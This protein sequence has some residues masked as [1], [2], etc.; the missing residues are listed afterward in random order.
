MGFRSLTDV[1]V[2]SFDKG[3]KIMGEHSFCN[4]FFF[5]Q[6][7]MTGFINTW[8]CSAVQE[9]CSVQVEALFHGGSKEAL[10]HDLFRGILWQ[11]Q[12]VHACVY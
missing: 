7:N 8:N 12:I 9:A 3:E 4:F 1:N 5:L 10:S 2:G 11:L 6:Q